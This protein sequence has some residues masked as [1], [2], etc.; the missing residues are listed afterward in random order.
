MSEISLDAL[1][2]LVLSEH[3]ADAARRRAELEAKK[4]TRL[5]DEIRAVI[6]AKMGDATEGT[7]DGKIAM[8]RT[9]SAQFAD[10]RFRKDHPDMYEEV[11]VPKLV[12]EVDLDKLKEIDESIVAQYSTVRWTNYIEVDE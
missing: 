6:A 3:R 9:E 1:R 2:G 12:Y 7:I 10:A 11:K 4:Y 5:R 8:R